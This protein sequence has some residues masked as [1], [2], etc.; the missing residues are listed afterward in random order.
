MRIIVDELACV[1]HGECMV[2][3]PE[4][5]DLR[6]DDFLVR[7]LDAEPGEELRKQAEA[8]LRVCPAE[9]IRIEG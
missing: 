7:M 3:A 5:F 2:V 6:D 8:A 4:L 1:A 9:A